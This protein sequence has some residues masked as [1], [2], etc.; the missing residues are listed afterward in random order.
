MKSTKIEFENDKGQKLAARIDNP[1]GGNPKAYAVFAHCFTCSKNLHTVTNISKSLTQSNIAVFR[2]DFTGLG[3]SEGDFEDTDFS[4]NVEDLICAINFVENNYQSPQILIG[5]SL[6]GAAMVKAAAVYGKASALVTI[7][8][9]ADPQHVEHLLEKKLDEIKEKGK[10]K[11]TIAGRTFT[12]K[13]IFLEDIRNNRLTKSLKIIDAAVLIMHS[14]VDKV[15][16]IDNATHLYK[17]ARHP[18]S[19]ISLD[20]SDHLLSRQ[21]DSEHAGQLIATWAD[22]YLN[23]SPESKLVPAKQVAARTGTGLATEIAT[24]DHSL[25]ADEPVDQ[26]GTNAG[27]SPYDLLAAALAS[28]TSM[29]IRM[30][31]DRKKWPLEEVTVHVEHK[32]DHVADC[33]TCESKD[34]KVDIFTRWIETEGDLEENQKQKLL[35]IANKCPV[36]RTLSAVIRIETKMNG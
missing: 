4:S 34:Q 9:P 31:A 3:E 10:A 7:G 21:E 20:K 13:K 28:C 22:K 35:E 25:W 12:I 33:N 18:K 36:H 32:R 2:F 24:M 19:F 16:E 6:G 5:H 15:V 8:A 23:I 14:P 26:G 11:I 27:P 17:K 1:V 30:Y 29:T